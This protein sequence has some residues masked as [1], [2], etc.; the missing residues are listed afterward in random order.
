MSGTWYAPDGTPR[1]P[2]EPSSGDD[3]FSGTEGQDFVLNEFGEQTSLVPGGEGNDTLDGRGGDDFL[4]GNEGD[5]LLLGGD[6][7]DA[8]LGGAGSDTLFGGEGDDDLNGIPGNDWIHGGAGSDTVQLAGSAAGYVWQ[9][10]AGGW[11][12]LDLDPSDGDDGSDFIADDVE[13][14]SYGGSGETVQT[15]CFAAGTRIM[16]AHGEVPVESL[17]A[18]DLVVTL[19]RRGA[20]LRPVRWIGRRRVD[21]VRHPRPETVLPVRIRAGA[22][23]PGV[24]HRDL[25]VSPDH[26]LFLDG[27]LVPAAALLDG[28]AVLQEPAGRPVTY[29]HVELDA[30]D[31]LLAEGAPAESW[32]DCGN[33]AQFDNAGPVV[34]LHARFDAGPGAGGDRC[35]PLVLPGAPALGRILHRLAQRRAGAPDAARRARG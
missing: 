21:C 16:T 4:V 25:R 6:G 7:A 33:R 27:M 13:W 18:G 28:E 19:G 31:L 1:T 8:L 20:W 29:F 11:N 23:G 22:L 26:A 17:R 10:T 30:H 3:S 15:P 5:D 35:A 34:A 12:V 14:V 2:N 32:L 9:P 24:P